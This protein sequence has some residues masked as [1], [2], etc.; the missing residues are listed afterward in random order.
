MLKRLIVKN[1]AI[2]K[3]SEIEFSEGFNVVTGETGAG[4]TILINAIKL[5]LGKRAK[6]NIIRIGEKSASVEAIFYFKKDNEIYKIL[7]SMGIFVEG[8]ELIIKRILTTNKQNRIYINGSLAT[9]KNLEKI[10]KHLF[11]I[12]SQSEQHELFSKDTHREILDQYSELSKK[13]IK[14]KKKYNEYHQ[15]DT[16]LQKLIKKQKD[17]A[18]KK[19]FYLFILNEQEKIDPKKGE[20]RE[21]EDELNIL[22]NSEGIKTFY[23]KL[24]SKLYNDRDSA[25]NRLNEIIYTAEEVRKYI[26]PAMISSLEDIFYSIENIAEDAK[27]SSNDLSVDSNRLYYLQD[28]LN[29]I[30]SLFNKYGGDEEQFFKKIDDILKQID[31]QDLLELEIDKITNQRE[32]IKENLISLADELHAIR[33]KKSVKFIKDIENNMRLLGMKNARFYISLAK[34][35]F[36][37]ITINGY[38]TIEFLIRTSINGNFEKFKDILSGGELSRILLS[39]KKVLSTF[40]SKCYIFDEID[41]GTG[42]DIAHQIGK[43]LLDVSKKDQIIVITHL[44]QVA[45]LADKHFYVTKYDKNNETISVIKALSNM[46]RENELSRMIGDTNLD[47]SKFF[48][49]TLFNKEMR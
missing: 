35:S 19:S 21:I 4:K 32:V 39:I 9:L 17:F 28:R 29:D 48:I 34:R 31:M 6:K 2:I 1:L 3:H 23:E 24:V 37:T 26:D 38:T 12:S 8:K 33:E 47:N 16:E 13:L 18:E 14:F 40:E 41:Q 5:F 10:S 30:A 11:G 49:K 43:L 45:A 36:D 27:N 44:I 15:I 42:G 7:E 46:E 20:L 22:E 25:Y